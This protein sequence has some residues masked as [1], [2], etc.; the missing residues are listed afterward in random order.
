MAL[1]RMVCVSRCMCVVVNVKGT[2]FFFFLGES[3][4]GHAHE[5]AQRAQ[6]SKHGGVNKYEMTTNRVQYPE[7]AR[8]ACQFILIL[9][10]GYVY[11]QFGDECTC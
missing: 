6:S 2:E 11:I 3:I 7:R 1:F 8:R 10:Y 9:R 4:D 5:A